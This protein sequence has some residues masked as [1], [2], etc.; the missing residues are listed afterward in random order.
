LNID[1][2]KAERVLVDHAVD[3]IIAATPKRAPCVGH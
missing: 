3:T 2:I 1:A